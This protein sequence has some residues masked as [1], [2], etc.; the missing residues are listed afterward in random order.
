VKVEDVARVCHEANKALCITLKDFSQLPWN[1]A[2]E[3]QR[4]S[5]INGV[6]FALDNPEAPAS[7]QHD[8][9]LADKERDGW[10]YGEV[11]DAEKKEH[12][13]IV[14]YEELPE[15]Q[16][17]KDYLFKAIVNSLYMLIERS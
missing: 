5:A 8:S 6:L 4:Q 11:K 15:E 3:W 16:K 14:A 13:C 9:W 12:P 17:A 7:A 2:E 10:K 1:L